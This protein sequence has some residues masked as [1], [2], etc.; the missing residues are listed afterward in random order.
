LSARSFDRTSAER[1]FSAQGALP[2]QSRVASGAQPALTDEALI[3]SIAVGDERALRQLYDR[4]GAV[5]YGL[6][7][8]VVRDPGLA[9]DAVQDAFLS[10]WRSASRFD[11][12]RGSARTWLLTLVHRRAVDLVKR[13]A[14]RREEPIKAPPESVTASTAEA[15]D[16]R[17]ERRRVRTAL[18][19]LPAR[20]RQ[21]I[22]LAYYGGY[23]QS[24]IAGLL[25]LP[26]GTIK[27]RMFAGLS[28]LRDLLLEGDEPLLPEQPDGHGSGQLDH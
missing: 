3:G 26:L 20:Q 1:I 21:T 9:E 4:F 24:Q 7:L 27:S 5:A 6:A 23:S 10:A 19:S 18:D 8:R 25:S 15:A 28:R 14:R 16:L 17:A 22:E 11:G 13:A 12:E 2:T